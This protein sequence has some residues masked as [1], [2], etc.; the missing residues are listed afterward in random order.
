[1]KMKNLLTLDELILHLIHS[2]VNFLVGF[3]ALK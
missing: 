1:M 3:C 2:V